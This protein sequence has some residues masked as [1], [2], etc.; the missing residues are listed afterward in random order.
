MFRKSFDIQIWNKVK[1]FSF[2]NQKSMF[3][4][5]K[6]RDKTFNNTENLEFYVS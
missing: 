5:E 6:K 2:K 3:F 1:L 4:I